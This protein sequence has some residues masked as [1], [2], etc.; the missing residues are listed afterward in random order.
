MVPHH[1]IAEVVVVPTTVSSENQ[2][3]LCS[4]L[5][6]VHARSDAQ[7]LIAWPYDYPVGRDA[8]TKSETPYRSLLAFVVLSIDHG[9]D[10]LD[11]ELSSRGMVRQDAAG[12]RA[13]FPSHQAWTGLPWPGVLKLGI[14]GAMYP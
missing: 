8:V 4:C 10:G 2:P 3:T 5:P 12:A 13:A 6:A 9:L 7:S 14:A 1:Y 11:C